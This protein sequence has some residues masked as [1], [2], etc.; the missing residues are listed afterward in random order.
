MAQPWFPNQ[1]QP[2]TQITYMPATAGPSL[3]QKST[4]SVLAYVW[5][6][7]AKFLRTA[8]ILQHKE[9]PRMTAN[10]KLIYKQLY[11]YISNMLRNTDIW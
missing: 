4:H 7:A 6:D 3:S 2:Q 9:K 8:D 1:D 10:N 5:G 11:L